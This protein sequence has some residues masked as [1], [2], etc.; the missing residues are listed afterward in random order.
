MSPK[1]AG[2]A[3]DQLLWLDTEQIPLCLVFWVTVAHGAHL[4]DTGWA[5]G[6]VEG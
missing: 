6:S 2:A 3:H 4:E 1:I 5:L